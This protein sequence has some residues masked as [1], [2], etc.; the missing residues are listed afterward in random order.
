MPGSYACPLASAAR[1]LVVGTSE[2]AQFTAIHDA[3]SQARSGDTIELLGGEYREQVRLRDGIYL[4]S[5]VPE[6][7]IIRAA[8]S[9][10]GPPIAIIAE[11]V[12]SGANVHARWSPV[13]SLG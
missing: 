10:A 5:R 1:V 12:K 13:W 8:P 4:T 2:G 7:A 11:K 6:A 3:L 9:Y